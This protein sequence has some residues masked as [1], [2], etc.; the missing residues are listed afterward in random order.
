MEWQEGSITM[1]NTFSNYAAKMPSALAIPFFAHKAILKKMLQSP[2][3][4]T[5][6]KTD[7]ICVSRR[8]RSSLKDVRTFRDADVG[9]G[10]HLVIGTVKLKLTGLQ[11]EKSVQPYTVEKLEDQSTARNS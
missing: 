10:H 9:S 3:G 4:E 7:Y 8:W 2:D 1:V 6:N 11:R 5:K